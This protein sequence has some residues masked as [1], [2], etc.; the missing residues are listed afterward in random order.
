MHMCIVHFPKL[1]ACL[2][3]ALELSPRLYNYAVLTIPSKTKQLYI[4]L[5]SWASNPFNKKCVCIYMSIWAHY[6]KDMSILFHHS[7]LI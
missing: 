3:M 7:I 6:K 5:A 4:A 1:L 2:K